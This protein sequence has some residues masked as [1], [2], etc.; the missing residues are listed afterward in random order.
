MELGTALHTAILEPEK[1]AERYVRGAAGN[2]TR[3]GPR[4]ENDR[5][6]AENPGKQ[7]V[8]DKDWPRIVAMR[9]AMWRHPLAR[10]VLSS[11]G[12]NE[13]AGLW[14]DPA[15]GLACKLRVDRFGSTREGWPV[16][17]DYK[18]FGEKGGRL[19][20]SA[21]ES[22][23]NNR[24]YHV[25]GA[26]YLNGMETIEP[27]PRRYVIAFQEKEPPF[28][29]RLVEVEFAA[30][31]LG[32]RQIARWLRRLKKCQDSQE[33]PGWSEGFDAL[34]VPHYAYTQEEEDDE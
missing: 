5:I 17:M 15:T 20:D 26:H 19:T 34:G 10:E 21:V 16:V 31:E 24:M 6:K 12:Y 4:E 27:C 7:L 2:L 14:V 3:K 33:W 23:I 28:A 25:Q 18:T 29:P 1:F 22:V 9:D 13:L 32:K 8:R 11:E 30:L